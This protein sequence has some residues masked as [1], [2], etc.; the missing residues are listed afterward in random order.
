MGRWGLLGASGFL[1][2]ALAI[3][4]SMH[5][6]PAEHVLTSIA[7]LCAIACYECSCSSR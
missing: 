4:F 1:L 6:S 7:I 5:D 3:P 2:A